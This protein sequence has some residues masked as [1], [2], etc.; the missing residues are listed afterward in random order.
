MILKDVVINGPSGSGK[1][2]F[3]ELVHVVADYNVINISSV[4][5]LRSIPK[6]WGWN[7]EKDLNYRK[8]LIALKEAAT[9]IDNYPLRYMLEKRQRIK[10]SSIKAV[11]FY[12]IRE[13]HNIEEFI[14]AIDDDVKVLLIRRF[15]MDEQTPDY[16]QVNEYK[17]YD[18]VITNVTDDYESLRTSAITFAKQ[19]GPLRAQ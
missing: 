3:V 5:P 14:E 13:P 18:Y 1:D 9:Y 2:S 8:A 17:H 11:I 15:P 12:H 4:D 19:W 6:Q 16:N 7:G 10:E